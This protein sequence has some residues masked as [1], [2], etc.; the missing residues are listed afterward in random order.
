MQG[1]SLNAL[2]SP[3]TCYFPAVTKTIKSLNT[4]HSVYLGLRTLLFVVNEETK[5]QKKSKRKTQ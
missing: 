5:K 4:N 3:I 2:K 1:E